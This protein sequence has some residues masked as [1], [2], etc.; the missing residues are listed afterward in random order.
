MWDVI[1]A[2]TGEELFWSFD[3]IKCEI[4]VQVNVSLKCKLLYIP[5]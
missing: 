4:F 2:L 3:R 5:I 1:D